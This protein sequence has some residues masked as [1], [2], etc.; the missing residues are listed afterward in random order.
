MCGPR[1]EASIIL[2]SMR[3]VLFQWLINPDHVSLSHMRDCLVANV[4]TV[5]Q[6]LSEPAARSLEYWAAARGDQPALF[7]GT[8]SL[9]YRDWNEYADMLAD[10]F[11]G[12]RPWR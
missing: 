5:A 2:A 12:A 3:G 7:E 6:G 10:A 8:A 1:A 11:A 4:R 9:T